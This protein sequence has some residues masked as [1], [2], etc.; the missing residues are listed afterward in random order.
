MS[1]VILQTPKTHL[2]DRQS[3]RTVH[4]VSTTLTSFSVKHTLHSFI[5]T[6]A[7]LYLAQPREV[8][9]DMTFELVIYIIGHCIHSCYQVSCHHHQNINRHDIGSY[10]QTSTLS[11]IHKTTRIKEVKLILEAQKLQRAV[12]PTLRDAS[13]C[14]PNVSFSAHGCFR[15]IVR[16]GKMLH[17]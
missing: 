7:A 14:H 12:H 1:E 8:S 6:K 15:V 17:G 16:K 2:K 11:F 5:E 13:S 3:N 9:R 10:M 4:A